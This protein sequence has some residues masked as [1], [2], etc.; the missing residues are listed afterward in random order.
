VVSEPTPPAEG[1]GFN[2]LVGLVEEHVGDGRARITL[3]AAER[4]LNPAGTVHGG[5][6]ATLIDV[7]MGRAMAS[8][9]ADD[10]RPITI[11][12]KINYLEAGAPGDIVAEADV[13]RRGRLFTVV[14]AEVTQRESQETIAEA[15]GTF[16][17]R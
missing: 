3:V 6:I 16:T 14:H 2:D 5:A 4:H 10:E 17:S 7:A 13:S 1:A 9:I 8:L 11:E 12:I 15:I